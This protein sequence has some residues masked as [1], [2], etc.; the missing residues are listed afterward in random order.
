[1]RDLFVGPGTDTRQWLSYGIVDAE[2]GDAHTVTFDD[3]DGAPLP[4]GMLVSVTLQPSGISLPCRV[5]SATAGAG[6]FEYSVMG[7]GD[8]V[9]VAIPEGDERAGGIILG[10]LANSKD[11]MPRTVAGIDV[12]KNSVSYKRLKTTYILETASTYMV[13]SALTGASIAIDA[14]G[15]ILLADGEGNNFS[16]NQSILSFGDSTGAAVVQINPHTLAVALMADTTSLE[17]TADESTFLSTGTLKIGTA[18]LPP[19]GHGVTAEQVA[20]LVEGLLLKI[21]AASPGPLTGATLAAAAASILPAAIAALGDTR[22]L[23]STSAAVQSALA[24]PPD[25]TATLP[26]FGRAGLLF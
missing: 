23:P 9:I 4:E 20:A 16:L 10:K 25:P 8:E 11:A 17:L 24:V 5:A 2:A 19:L 1:M 22:P 7:P 3:D 15:N 6:E 14:T 13:R 26:G 21:G 18:G 12:T